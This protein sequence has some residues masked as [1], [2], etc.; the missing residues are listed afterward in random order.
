MNGYNRNG[1]IFFQVEYQMFEIGTGAHSMGIKCKPYLTRTAKQNK[2]SEPNSVLQ[3]SMIVPEG[4]YKSKLSDSDLTEISNTYAEKF[5][6][7]DL[8]VVCENISSD[9]VTWALRKMHLI[10]KRKI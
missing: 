9:S 8:L 10:R 4:G 5:H 3:L 7:S 1:E 6:E 2:N